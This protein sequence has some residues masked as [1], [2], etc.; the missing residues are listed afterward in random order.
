MRANE[1][2]MTRGPLSGQILRFT[3]PLILSRLLQMVF[4]LAD[5][6]VIGHFA[7][8]LALG[9]VGSTTT[10]VAFMTA[11]V[12][13]MGGGVN[14]VAGRYLGAKAEREVHDV[15]HT[16]LL[17]CLGVGVFLLILG[18]VL[19]GPVLRL[20]KTDPALLEGAG[21]Y[22][23]IYLFSMPAAGLFNYGSA[24]CSA[25]GETRKP[26][27]FLLLAGALNVALNLAFVIW[28]RMGIAGVAA[29]SVISQYLSA[30]LMLFFLFRIQGPCRLKLSDVRMHKEHALSVFTLG[31]SAGVQEAAFAL[32]NLF[33]QRAINS[34][35]PDTVA[36]H[37]VALNADTIVFSV[38]GGFWT[39][40]GSFMSRNFGAGKKRRFMQV[41][42]LCLLYTFLIGAVFGTLLI[43]FRSQFLSLFTPEDA[44][45]EAGK[46]R[47]VMLAA[48]YPFCVTQDTSMSGLRAMG[49]KLVP[50]LISL[51]GIVVFRVIWIYTVF[52]HFGTLV[53]LYAL[54]LFSFLFCGAGLVCYFLRCYRR[55]PWPEENESQ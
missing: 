30:F 50:L 5:Q 1:I 40:S 19:G 25:M 44:I 52:A 27:L 2:D 34:F 36:G 47:L 13:G 24:V 41:Y 38:M 8:P 4:N 9:E 15:V 6:A 55:C 20:L 29:A 53:S 14:A 18:L 10:L 39:A 3:I 35:G 23:R 12:W 33:L 16:S 32:S 21:L 54:Y 48:F 17:V 49:K 51:S 26:F 28:F 45:I 7:G 11:F 46:Y 31:L 43:L 37:A 42:L 22:L